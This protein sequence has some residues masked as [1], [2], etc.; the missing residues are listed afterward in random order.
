MFSLLL[1]ASAVAPP[2]LLESGPHPGCGA[3]NPALF[4]G[5]PG[6][7]VTPTELKRWKEYVAELELHEQTAMNE[8]WAAADYAGRKKLLGLLDK[9]RAD[10]DKKRKDEEKKLNEEKKN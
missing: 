7:T 2:F 9:L 5:S 1:L 6:P 10:E 4:A 3:F 8:V